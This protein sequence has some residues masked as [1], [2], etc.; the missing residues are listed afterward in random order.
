VAIPE[1]QLET[2]TG[3]G[4]VAQ[5][6][7]TYDI[8]KKVIE[9]ANAPYASKRIDSFLQGSYR[10]N[11]NIYGD[12]D[13]DIV[14]RTSSLFHYKIDTLPDWQQAL[15]H[16]DHPCAAEYKLP[17]FRKD[18]HTWLHE[19]YADHLD[20]SGKKAFRIR[21]GGNRRDADVLLVA[22]HKTFTR[23][24]GSQQQDQTYL[25]ECS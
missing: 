5:S 22:P 11:S 6:A 23:D 25:L 19:N 1:K 24:E 20:A 9:H 16:T 18:V 21:A 12:S 7:A 17:D 2:W 10:N 14:L 3:L 15:L 13:V 8:I 4:S